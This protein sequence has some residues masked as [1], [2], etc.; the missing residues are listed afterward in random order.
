MIDRL[1][2]IVR[3]FTKKRGAG[4]RRWDLMIWSAGIAA[5]LGIPIVIA[6]PRA[7]PLVWL[8]VLSIPANSPLSPIIPA[9][10]EPL[11]MEA[12]K[13]EKA[14]WVTLVALCAY[15]YMEYLNWH[16]YAWVLGRRAL[17]GLREQRWIQRSLKYFAFA[18]F[19]TVVFFAFTPMP[20]WAIRTL[21]IL[22]GYPI[23]TF[24]AATALGRFP[25]LF[26]YAW[27]GSIFRIPT[28]V[29]VGVIFGT[30]AAVILYKLL[31][32]K[33]LLSDTVM[34][35]TAEQPDESEEATSRA[36]DV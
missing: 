29:L 30:A 26:A 16:A 33:K 3:F 7:I 12:A 25:R 21:A 32:G 31:H 14:I 34:D 13:Y 6:F 9:A 19:G 8:A 23:R 28:L 17:K 4:E 24:M 11:I 20:F 15:M 27:L 2:R 22:D 5:L 18:P 36:A 10:F 35:G 1:L